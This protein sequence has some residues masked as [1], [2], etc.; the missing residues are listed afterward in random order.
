MDGDSFNLYMKADDI[1]K[2]I[3]ED[4]ETRFDTS[5]CELVQPLPKGKKIIW[6]NESWIRWKNHD[7]SCW[8][9]YGLSL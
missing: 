1:Y 9:N 7:K 6:I 5:N 3:A 4:V 8:V 2:D